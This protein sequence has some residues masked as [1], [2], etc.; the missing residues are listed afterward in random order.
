MQEIAAHVFIENAYP[1][2]TLGVIDWPHGQV[3][4]DA[5]LRPDDIRLWRSTLA[6][7]NPSSDRLL[8]NLDEHY[9]RTIGARQVEC[10]VVGHEKMGQLFRDRPV[11]FKSQAVETGAE[12][13]L[14]NGLGS[15]RWAPPDISFSHQLE[16]NWDNHPILLEYHPG[17]AQCSI[18]VE[19]PQQKVVFVG[20]TIVPTEP[21]FLSSASLTA[22]KEALTT[23][24]TPKY[25]D[26]QIISGRGGVVEHTAIKEQIKFLE[27]VE[28]QLAKLVEKKSSPIEIE[29]TAH[30]LVKNFESS[31]DRLAHHVLRLNWGLQQY[32]KL[33]PDLEASS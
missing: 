33:H 3:F 14:Q 10:L 31:E 7:M 28:H 11:T 22:W 32:L 17:P 23:L 16:L 19:L 24:L 8:V 30:A 15:I 21:P 9:D 1:G 29:K 2:V 4:I 5:P 12:W 25:R 27:K 6:N 20:D 13:E 26:Y 18:W